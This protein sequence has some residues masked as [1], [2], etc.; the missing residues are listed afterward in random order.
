MKLKILFF[1][2]LFSAAVECDPIWSDY[3]EI[4]NLYPTDY[5]LAFNTLYKNLELSSCDG[6]T[7]FILN[8]DSAEYNTQVSVLIAAFMAQKR[9]NLY[10]EDL[11]A[12]CF[13]TVIRFRV[14]RY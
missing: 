14:A 9:V 6:G 1:L 10:I 8:K 3:T 12:K 11:P 4:T 2:S 7:R 13:A 5:G